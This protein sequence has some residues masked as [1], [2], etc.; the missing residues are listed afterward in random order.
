MMQICD[1]TEK[2]LNFVYSYIWNLLADLRMK[3]TDMN[4]HSGASTPPP[5]SYYNKS[6][7][8]IVLVLVIGLIAIVFIHMTTTETTPASDVSTINTAPVKNTQQEQQNSPEKMRTSAKLNSAKPLANTAEEKSDANSGAARDTQDDI[9]CTPG[10]R[11]A[12]L[13]R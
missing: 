8:L 13:C 10:D 11:E 6:A 7:L 3:D 1:L 5:K 4:Y 2:K 12:G 9:S